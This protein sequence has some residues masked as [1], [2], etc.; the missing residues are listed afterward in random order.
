MSLENKAQGIQYSE[1]QVGILH[2]FE[3]LISAKGYAAT[4]V[5]DI[6]NAA[7]INVAMISYYFGS[8][9][10]LLEALFV[11]RISSTR[12]F[13]QSLLDNKL[14]NPFQKMEVLVQNFVD[15]WLS[16][17]SFF[18]IM[19]REPALK[20]LKKISKL[21]HSTKLG[22][23]KMM[24]SLI[25]EGQSAQLFRT[26]ID[27][28]LLMHSILGSIMSV[29]NNIDYLKIMYKSEQLSNDMFLTQLRPKL[30]KHILQMITAALTPSEKK[31]TT[32]L[33]K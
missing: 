24:S 12:L 5:R 21:L 18:Q 25:E 14:M 32:I 30:N 7:K 27:S 17:F 9:E 22:N 3:Q 26:D 19:N 23:Q 10:K 11:Y 8:K 13:L 4:S 31:L 2:A 1:K 28:V 29:C 20:E 15:K 16:N 6:A 33:K